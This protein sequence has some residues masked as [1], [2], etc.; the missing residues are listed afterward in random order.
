M[1]K[2][3]II[4]GLLVVAG[5]IAFFLVPRNQ[6]V[7]SLA[8]NSFEDC[9]AAGNPVME[10]NP[11]QCRTADG[12]LFTKGTEGS[13]STNPAPT[14][15]SV[16]PAGTPTTQNPAADDSDSMVA[17]TMDAKIC[18]DGSAVGRVGPNCNFAACPGEPGGPVVLRT[19]LGEQVNGHNI[20]IKPVAILEDSRCPLNTQCVRAGQVRLEAEVVT[21]EGGDIEVLTSGEVFKTQTALVTLVEVEPPKQQGIIIDK[22]EYVF[23]FKVEL[24]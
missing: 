11:E 24:R 1:K 23:V 18:P 7:P 19:H 16:T 8:I 9:V 6:Q 20:A 22:E 3:L 14:N 4:V 5:L 13:A 17:C 12:R 15:T 10:S 21:P 2:I